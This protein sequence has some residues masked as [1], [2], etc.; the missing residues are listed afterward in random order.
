MDHPVSSTYLDQQIARAVAA[1]PAAGAWDATPTA[2]AC[3]GFNSMTLAVTYDE[4]AG[5]VAG[6]MDLQI[7]WSPDSTGT[8]WHTMSLYAPGVLA[9]GVET[10]SRVQTEYVTFAPVGATNELFAYGPIT[11]A[12]TIE[13]VAVRCRESGQVGSPGACSVLARFGMGE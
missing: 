3:P 12:G 10:Q 8:V 5:G 6:A 11:L 13:R 9:A 4:N 2:M 7:L 1:L